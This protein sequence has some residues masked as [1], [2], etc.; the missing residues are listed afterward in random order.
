MKK[1]EFLK[2]LD[3]AILLE[4]NVTSIYLQHVRALSQKVSLAQEKKERL[5]EVMNLL[6]SFNGN[7]KERCEAMVKEIQ[8][9]NK[10]DY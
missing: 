1:A 3:E 10:S 5:I 9:E 4:E 6:I 2:S 7:H 8:G